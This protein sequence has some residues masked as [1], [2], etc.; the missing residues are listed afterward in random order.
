ML[1]KKVFFCITIVAALAYGYRTI[2]FNCGPG[3]TTDPE[4]IAAGCP[5]CPTQEPAVEVVIEREE[6]CSS[7]NQKTDDFFH[8]DVYTTGGAENV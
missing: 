5:A 4:K 7:C 3:C 8:D 2:T 6:E 1:S